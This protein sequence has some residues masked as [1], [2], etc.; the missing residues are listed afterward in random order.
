VIGGFLAI[1]VAIVGLVLR[2]VRAEIAI[3]REHIDG[4]RNELVTRF[5]GLERDVQRLYEHAF[6][7]EEPPAT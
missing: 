4:L 7:C 5:D 1:L 6:A 3:L 2:L